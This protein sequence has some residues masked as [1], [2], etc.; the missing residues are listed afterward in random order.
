M[1]PGATCPSPWWSSFFRSPSAGG[2]PRRASLRWPGCPSRT[3]AKAAKGH[4]KGCLLVM[5]RVMSYKLYDIVI[6]IKVKVNI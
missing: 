4:P 3:G 1:G 2:S 5:S 6:H